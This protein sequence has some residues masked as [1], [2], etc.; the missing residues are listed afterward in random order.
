M[1]DS[2]ET[3]ELKFEELKNTGMLPSPSGVGMQIL[4]LT[5]QED[6][7][8]EELA[9]IIQTD[10]ALTGRV[11]KV[12]SS[13][14]YTGNHPVTAVRDA[15]MR[16]G[17]RTLRSVALGFTLV[18]GNRIGKCEGFDYDKYWTW[19]LANA[20]AAQTISSRYG[21]G[22]PAEA[23]T[24]ALLSRIGR[25]ALASVYPQ[26]FTDVLHRLA[27]DPGANLG[28]VENEEFGINHKHV[29]ASMIEDWGLPP[30]FG[31][32]ILLFDDNVPAVLVDNP[33]AYDL[34]RTLRL[35]GTLAKLFVSN[36]KS[37]PKHWLEGKRACEELDLNE[38][39]YGHLFEEIRPLWS[40]WGQLLDVPTTEVPSFE[41]LAARAKE[42]VSRATRSASRR[43]RHKG[44]E[45]SVLR[46]LAVDDDP[47]TLRLLER[48]LTRAGHQVVT[49]KN[50]KEALG[51]AL[52]TNPQIVIT[53]WMMPEMDGIELCKALRRFGSGRNLYVLILT[54]QEDE[55][56]LVEAFEA[57]ADDYVT[58]PLKPRLLNARIRGGQRVVQLQEQVERDKRTQ[59]EQVTKMAVLNRKLHAAAKADALTD[60]PN[61]R[62][63]MERLEKE[64][65]NSS[66]SHSPFSVIMLDVD[67]FKRIN[68]T[69]GHDVGDV[70]LQSTAKAITRALR[71][72]DVCARMGGEEFLVICPQTDAVGAHQVAERIRQTV[73]ENQVAVRDFEGNVTMSLGVAVRDAG[74]SSINV[75]LRV[76]DE[77]VYLA[78][79]EGRNCVRMGT[80]PGGSSRNAS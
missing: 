53:D 47:T 31:E 13:V 3:F 29:G 15:A 37:K 75:L 58:K 79:A 33:E 14:L 72:G 16:L 36:E 46:V 23:F 30:S 41:E 22:L 12:A 49:A 74:V 26:R 50:G 43:P 59:R 64:W 1:V 54:A 62:Y 51:M 66:R 19:S 73:E 65:A 38:E 55:D 35:S 52:Q 4:V 44:P 76:S 60:L 78:K 25:L 2:R 24:C 6:C 67:H 17:L 45:S 80:S 61:R 28:D 57:G 69:Y 27:R 71:R 20:V 18:T 63:A 21:L 77:A 39:E 56:H 9:K 7:S 70:V 8:I 11:L 10:P 32:A 34:L 68:D 40:E 42:E 48:V 5:Q